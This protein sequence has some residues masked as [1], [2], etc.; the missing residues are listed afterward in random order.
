[1]K[2]WINTVFQAHVMFKKQGSFVQAGHGKE[3]GYNFLAFFS[4]NY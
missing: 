4:F 3:F 1:M 2:Y